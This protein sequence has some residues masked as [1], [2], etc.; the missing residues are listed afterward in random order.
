MT[1]AFGIPQQDQ[2]APYYQQQ[3]ANGQPNGFD[4]SKPIS[5]SIAFAS[6]GP[7]GSMA[8]SFSN[9]VNNLDQ[10][11][12]NSY[13]YPSTN[14]AMA[15]NGQ[16]MAYAGAPQ[17]QQQVQP[18]YMPPPPQ[19]IQQQ[20]QPA[21]QQMA[22]QQPQMTD[23]QKMQFASGVLQLVAMIL[24]MMGMQN[25]GQTQAQPA[26][27]QGTGKDINVHKDSRG[28]W[29]DPHYHLKGSDGKDINFDHKGKD[30]HIYHI[31]SG[32]NLRIDGKYIPFKDPNNPQI[33]GD[34]NVQAGKDAVQFTKEGDLKINGEAKKDGTYTLADGTK[35]VAKGKKIDLITP[36]NDGSKVTITA[37]GGSG[38]T[39]DPEGKFKNSDGIIGKAISENRTL[40]KEECEKF[41]MGKKY[42]P[43]PQ[44]NAIA[45]QGNDQFLQLLMQAFGFMQPQKA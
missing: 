33:V 21:Y 2:W 12:Q 11:L 31:F 19:Q 32:D 4:Y 43:A 5:T 18:Q 16:A 37:D 34:V 39:V 6:S 7:E 26:V 38:M 40:S 10:N 29:G 13:T 15:G 14:F 36:D 44:Q 9:A 41:D 28:E 1:P 3:V 24:Q 27:N 20:P 23:Q 25:Q 45:P 22:Q 42:P 30:N 8:F 35:V 17:Q